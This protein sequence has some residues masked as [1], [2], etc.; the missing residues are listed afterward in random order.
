M[1]AYNRTR[2]AAR[3]NRRRMFAHVRRWIYKASRPPRR[4][5][6]PMQAFKTE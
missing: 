1:T 6:A 5:A 2:S 3:P 4:V